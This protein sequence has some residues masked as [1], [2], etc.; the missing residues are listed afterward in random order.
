MGAVSTYVDAEW[1]DLTAAA[2]YAHISREVIR[3]AIIAGQLDAYEKPVSRGR[4]ACAERKNVLLR[5]SKSDVDRWIRR[6]WRKADATTFGLS[7]AA[8][9]IAALSATA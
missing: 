7:E 3:G 9:E 6:S 2:K 1:M 4:S 8:G 5:I